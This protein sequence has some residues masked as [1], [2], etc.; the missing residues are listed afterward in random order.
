MQ[1]GAVWSALQTHSASTQ[2]QSV[3]RGISHA[4]ATTSGA[5]SMPRHAGGKHTGVITCSCNKPSGKAY[6]LLLADFEDFL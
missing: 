4:P 6:S 1:L 3:T 5:P 2:S